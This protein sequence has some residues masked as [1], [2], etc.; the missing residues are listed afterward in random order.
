M[1]IAIT[2]ATGQVGEK[3]TQNLIDTNHDLILLSR[4]E[5]T[6]QKAV[7]KGAKV[8]AGDMSD[9]HFLTQALKGVETFYMMLPPDN[10]S[11]DVLCHFQTVIDSAVTAIK[12]NKISRVVFQSSYGAQHTHG[13]GPIVGCNTAEKAFKKVAKNFYA[14]R[15]SYFME[16]F[17]W[18]AAPMTGDSIIPL[19]VKGQSKTPFVATKDIAD[20]AA[21]VL[22]D[23][24]WTGHHVREVLGKEDLSF[25]EIAKIISQA[26]G[27]NIKHF[28]MSDDIA[29]ESLTK[30]EVG[31]SPEY[32][33]LFVELHRG[34][35]K[36][37]LCP[38]FLRN[39]KSTTPTRFE[40]FVNAEIAPLFK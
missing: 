8:M 25:D 16:N 20:I 3:I 22:T 26:A 28:E 4:K 13:T 19:P 27:K 32:A 38:E 15:N 21:K 6:A 2:G 39:S 7:A 12:A 5:N 24:T 37:H 10:F 1:R 31:F 11:N 30:P 14:L 35:D 40:D 18:M 33:A 36:G 29:L 23:E 34:I 9:T 17:K